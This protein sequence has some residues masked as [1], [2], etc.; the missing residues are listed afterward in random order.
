MLPLLPTMLC[1]TTQLAKTALQLQQGKVESI[2]H[3]STFHIINK[4]VLELKNAGCNLLEIYIQSSISFNIHH[5]HT[6]TT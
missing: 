2:A 5:Y 4:F 6:I 1:T 3:F